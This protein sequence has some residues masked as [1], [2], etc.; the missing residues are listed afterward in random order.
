MGIFSGVFGVADHESAIP[1][2]LRL[3]LLCLFE[4]YE[5]KSPIPALVSVDD[6]LELETR[7]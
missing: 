6:R 4:D 3:S 2:A 1:Q 5:V 7:P